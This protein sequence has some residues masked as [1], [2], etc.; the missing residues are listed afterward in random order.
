MSTHCDL[1]YAVIVPAAGEGRR[2]GGCRKPFLMLAGRPVI[3]HVVEALA[4]APGCVRIVLALRP[5]DAADESVRAELQALGQHVRIVPGGATRQ[6]SVAAGL[7]GVD[8]DVP[9]VLTHDAARPLVDPDVVRRV[10]QGALSSGAAVAAVPAAETVK[11][12]GEGG[13]VLGTPARDG[14][15]LAHTP[16]G[17]RRHL[18][19]R[20]HEAARRDGFAGTDDV[21][22]AERLGARV[23]VVEDRYDNIKITTPEDLAIAEAILRWR[24]GQ[25][26]GGA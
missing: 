23:I 4:R 19:E 1:R 21:Q 24:A 17:L 15:W 2:M 22:L 16:Q 18:F 20:A 12:V 3:G 13:I 10:A 25:P 8:V 14:L 9:V 6:D 11:E 7:R 26:A 5:D